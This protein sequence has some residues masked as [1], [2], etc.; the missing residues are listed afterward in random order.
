MEDYRERLRT[1]QVVSD[2]MPLQQRFPLPDVAMPE[3][4]VDSKT[5]KLEGESPL[6]LDNDSGSSRSGCDDDKMEEETDAETSGE[7][8]VDMKM[9]AQ[10]GLELNK[11]GDN[12]SDEMVE[13]AVDEREENPVNTL[14]ETRKEALL[15]EAK[16]FWDNM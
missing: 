2:A 8:M 9:S 14:P 15:G 1:G 11:S 12:L 5:E 10:D 16:T 6:S 4:E 13:M 3:A 7:R